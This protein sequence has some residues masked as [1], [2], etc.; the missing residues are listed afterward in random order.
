MG[1]AMTI[2]LGIFL[3]ALFVFLG[4]N[5]VYWVEYILWHHKVFGYWRWWP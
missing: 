3:G 4:V 5:F 1:N 2:A